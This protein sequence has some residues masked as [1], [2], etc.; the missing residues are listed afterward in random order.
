MVKFNLPN[1]FYIRKC[2]EKNVVLCTLAT[3][4]EEGG[5]KN[6]KIVGYYPD[7]PAAFRGCIK[8]V[9]LSADSNK[10]LTEIVK[11]LEGLEFKAK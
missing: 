7:Y 1:N 4:K 6:E 3:P 5:K 11:A 10:E 9:T 8:H 2:D